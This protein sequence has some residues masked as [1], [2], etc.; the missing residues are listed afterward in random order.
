MEVYNSIDEMFVE[1]INDLML[2][3]D[4]LDSRN[5]GSVEVLGYCARLRQPAFNMLRNTE[6]KVSR[7]YGLAELMWYLG[8]LHSIHWL[9]PFAPSYVNYSDDGRTAYGAYGPRGLSLRHLTHV[10]EILSDS[11]ESRQ[12]VLPIWDPSDLLTVKGKASKD[13]PCTVSLKFYVRNDKLNMIADMRSNDVWLG[14]PYDVF[15]FTTIQL[16]VATELGL[17]C[18]WYQH[19]AGSMHLYDKNIDRARKALKY[20]CSKPSYEM[21]HFGLDV[22]QELVNGFQIAVGRNPNDA[23]LTDP[24]LR[25][26]ARELNPEIPR[27]NDVRFD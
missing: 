7:A 27:E 13:I 26:I 20:D 2:S 5:G 10:A 17:R 16:I 23:D 6:R 18:G 14:M 3:G 22:A 12:C 25:C 21:H 8:G 9:T 15:C 11:P 1:T 4:R 19:Q 24:I